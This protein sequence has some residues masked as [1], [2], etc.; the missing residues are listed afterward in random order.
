MEDRGRTRY[1]KSSQ[2]GAGFMSLDRSYPAAAT[3]VHTRSK[4]QN[5]LNRRAQAILLLAQASDESGVFYV[6]DQF[7]PTMEIR[8]WW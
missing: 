3:Q 4:V 5:K 7:P 8:V 2:E 6:G 1:G